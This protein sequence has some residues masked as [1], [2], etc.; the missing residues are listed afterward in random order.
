MGHAPKVVR[1]AIATTAER[2][3]SFGISNPLEVEMARAIPADLDKRIPLIESDVLIN[4][5]AFAE[6]CAKE[7]L[8]LMRSPG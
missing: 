2:G 1:E 3:L 4:E 6:A 8:R 5:P 7:L